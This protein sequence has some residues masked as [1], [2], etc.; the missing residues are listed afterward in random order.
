MPTLISSSPYAKAGPKRLRLRLISSRSIIAMSQY[1]RD[2]VL[3]YKRRFL[4]ESIRKSNLMKGRA[5]G[6][7]PATAKRHTRF[8]SRRPASQLHPCCGGVERDPGGYQ[9]PDQGAGGRA[10]RTAV[11]PP[12]PCPDADGGRSVIPAATARRAGP[13]RRC[14]R[15]AEGRRQRRRFDYQY[16][17]IVRR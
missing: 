17:R 10:G 15:P 5:D 7:P 12:Q 11:P 3:A 8:R 14:H 16:A 2:P 9:P 6:P 1:L 4:I 13:D